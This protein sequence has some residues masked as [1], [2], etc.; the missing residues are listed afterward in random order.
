MNY[1]LACITLFQEGAVEVS[2]KARGQTIS[3]A[4][5]IAEI[6]RG[7][8][9]KNINI[10]DITLGTDLLMSEDDG[11]PSNISTIEIVLAK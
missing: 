1:V 4:V 11:I 7:R 8:F 5:D 6:T 2:L 3:R 10:K 9:L